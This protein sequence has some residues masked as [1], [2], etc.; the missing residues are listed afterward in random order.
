MPNFGYEVKATD[1][2][3]NAG[4]KIRGSVFTIT[5][6]GEASKI[7]VGLGAISEGTPNVKCAIYKHSD[8]TLVPNSETDARLISVA[9]WPTVTWEE[10]IISGNKPSLIQGTEYVLVVWADGSIYAAWDTGDADQGHYDPAIYGGWPDP[11]T[12]IFTGAEK[13]S[14]FCTYEGE[15]VAFIPTVAII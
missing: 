15:A 7:T 2:A 11:A 9:D 5:E 6:N 1:S 14:I 3:S 13:Y 10:F 8:S 12:F 4:D